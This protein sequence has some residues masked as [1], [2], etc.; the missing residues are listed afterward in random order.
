VFDPTFAC[1]LQNKDELQIPLD[2][3]QIPTPKVC[4]VRIIW[5]LSVYLCCWS[6]SLERNM[7]QTIRTFFKGRQNFFLFFFTKKGPL[8]K[9]TLDGADS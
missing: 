3:E 6:M 1:I 5:V 8:K 2:L 4:F 9:V 7:C